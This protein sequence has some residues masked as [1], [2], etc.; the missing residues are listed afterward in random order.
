MI[1]PEIH[2]ILEI[3]FNKEQ[4]RRQHLP[5]KDVITILQYHSKDITY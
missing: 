1:N 4:P 2:L 5:L 3:I